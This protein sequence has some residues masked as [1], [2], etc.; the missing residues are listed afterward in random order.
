MPEPIDFAAIVEEVR[1]APSLGPDELIAWGGEF[2]AARLASFLDAWDFWKTEAVW[3]LWLWPH[4]ILLSLDSD[5]P[6]DLAELERGRLFG[7]MGD[8]EVRRNGDLFLWRF[9]GDPGSAVQP[10]QFGSVAD[11]WESSAPGR[12]C[13]YR[14]HALLWG[15]RE[16]ED[17]WHDDRVAWA[18]L[19]YPGVGGCGRVQLEYTE[20]LD[21]ANVELVRLR[22]LAPHGESGD[23]HG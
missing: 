6:G 18:D 8:L 17:R 1:S 11:Y 22:R 21:G 7:E 13:E 14:R 2:D 12:L 16:E 9:V 15:Q 20:Y 10:A 23:R 19:R 5:L 3:K 4:K